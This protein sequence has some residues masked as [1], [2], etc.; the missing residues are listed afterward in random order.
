MTQVSLSSKKIAEAFNAW[1]G[2]KTCA[3]A[4]GSIDFQ[5]G[6]LRNPGAVI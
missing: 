1:R 2:R 5:A 3:Q 4:I 6:E